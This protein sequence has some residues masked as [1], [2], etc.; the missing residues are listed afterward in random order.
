MEQQAYLDQA[1]SSEGNNHGVFGRS[2]STTGAGVAGQA[3]ATSGV[4]Y[5]VY[6]S[7]DSPEG[8]GGAFTNLNPTGI[9]LLASGSGIIQSTAKSYIW[10][11]GN[12]V[13]PYRQSDSTTIDMTN[14][15][16]ARITQGA[17][18][19]HKNVMLPITITGP[20]FGQNVRIT[21]LDI[22]WIGASDLDAITAILMRRQTGVCAT[23]ACYVNILFDTA[24]HVCEVSQS[25]TGCTLHYD[26]LSNNVLTADSG[27]IY[28]TIELAFSS[29]TS[30]IDIGGVRLT[31]SHN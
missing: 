14:Q 25:P 1:G 17:T 23:S 3:I 6:G 2:A 8:R 27:I 26:Q 30:W 15:G 24:D 19:G 11:S 10:V 31:L 5:G 12:G 7:A 20:L 18:A 22:Y 21:G 29:E 16:G 4:T 28:L 13:R 9:A